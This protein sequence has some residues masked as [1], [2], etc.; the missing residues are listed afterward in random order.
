LETPGS[1]AGGARPPA[2]EPPRPTVP[3]SHGWAARH[4]RGACYPSAVAALRIESLSKRFGRAVAVAD[5][6]LTVERGAVYG[7]LGPNGAGKTTTL[8]CALG[9]LR[10]DGGRIEILGQPAAA[11]HRTRGRVAA[12][13]DQPL[14]VSNLTVAQN[15]DYA[16]RLLG[17]AGG[18]AADEALDLVGLAALK[19]RRAG[20]LS[21]GQ[22]RRLAIARAL[23]GQP[24]LLVLGEPL[25]GL[26][27]PGVRSMLELF[28][29]LAGAGHTLLLSSHRLHEMERVVTDVSVIIGGRVVREAPLDALLGEQSERLSIRATPAGDAVAALADLEGPTVL[30]DGDWLRVD[31]GGVPPA[32]VNRRLME[33]GCEVSALVPERLTLQAV[34]ESLLDRELAEATP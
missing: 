3:A 32:V 7:L 20:K 28:R 33:A 18:R 15:L 1:P 26:D 8:A 23:L 14:L 21:L 16:R 12:V 4:G 30:P 5:V 6:S 31:L 10:P 34:V 17:H 29:T 13:F 11:I 24:E 2:S 22:G 9:C 27:T 19:R 25:S